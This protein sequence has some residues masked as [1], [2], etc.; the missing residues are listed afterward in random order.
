M[1]R[2]KVKSTGGVA[3]ITPAMIEAQLMEAKAKKIELL[4]KV[5]IYRET[6]KLEEFVPHAKQQE[7][8]DALQDGRLKTFVLLSGNRFGKTTAAVA[9]AISLALGRFPWIKQPVAVNRAEH[10]SMRIMADKSLRVSYHRPDASSEVFDFA[11]EKDWKQWKHDQLNPFDPGA[12]RWKPPIKIRV[13][14]EDMTALEQVQL[15]KFRSYCAPEWVVARKKNSFG[16]DVHWVFANGSV[17][18]FLT[19]NQDS[20]TLEG[21]D[22]HVALYDEPPP[23]SHY[24]ANLR[25]LVDHSGLSIFSMTPIREPWINDEIVSKPDP[26]IWSMTGS[27]RDNPHLKKS[28]ID[29]FE[30][31]LT[32]EEKE[33]RLEGHF[34]HL[35]GIVFREFDKKIH[36]KPCREPPKDSTVYCA[37]DP[38]ART[39]HALVFVWVDRKGNMFVCHD[40][41]RNGTPDQIAEWVIAFHETI[42]P[43]EQVI[44]DPYSKG[45]QNRGETT[46]E[47][48]ERLLA[49]KGIPL[50][51]GSKDLA[52]GILQVQECLKSRNGL[53]SLFIDPSCERTIFE[54][55]RIVWADWKGQGTDKEQMNKPVAKDNHMWENIRRLIQYPAEYRSPRSVSDLIQRNQWKPSDDMAG[56]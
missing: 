33:S 20:S 2:D 31:A 22:G 1:A 48:V 6:H 49:D 21:W 36:V 13:L 35:S 5:R 25:G 18:D 7:F 10:S 4:E 43:V 32:D 16:L 53:A 11:S 54:V 39:P 51:L 56:Y 41:F 30:A 37:I 19:Y 55:Q 46:Y 23:R 47:I 44:I 42:H 34:L 24:I 15:P 28:D 27:T 12:L 45:D 38:H 52:S 9:A 50:D 40:I 3:V 14:A 29:Q 17:I 8:F 26:S